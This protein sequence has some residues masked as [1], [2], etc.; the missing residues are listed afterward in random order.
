[1]STRLSLICHAAMPA[2]LGVRFWQ[3]DPADPG[4]LAAIGVWSG[5][6]RLWTAPE[7]RARQTADRLASGAMVQEVL[8]DCDF[9][10]WRGRSLVELEKSDPE[11]VAAWLADMGSTHHGG[12][13]VQDLI[14]R[15]G[16]WLDEHCEPGH[17]VAVTHPAVIRAAITHCLG[18]PPPAFWRIDVEPLAVA[19]LRRFGDRWTLRSLGIRQA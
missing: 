1:M 9:G 19:D 3:D 17:T 6:D 5:I 2:S 10:A 13:S 8:H 12:E 15:I 18:A 7:I 14:V 16:H 11:G 4:E